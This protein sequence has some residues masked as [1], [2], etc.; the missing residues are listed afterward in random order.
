VDKIGDKKGRSIHLTSYAPEEEADSLAHTLNALQLYEEIKAHPSKGHLIHQSPRKSAPLEH[1]R[2]F[3]WHIFNETLQPFISTVQ[4]QVKQAKRPTTTHPSTSLHLS[5]KDLRVVVQ[6]KLIESHFDEQLFTAPELVE[7]IERIIDASLIK[8]VL[9]RE[10]ALYF[11]EWVDA[12]PFVFVMAF[13]L[14][15]VDHKD[16][17]LVQNTVITLHRKDLMDFTDEEEEKKR[18]EA[19][20]KQKAKKERRNAAATPNLLNTLLTGLTEDE[21]PAGMDVEEPI[22]QAKIQYLNSMTLETE[23]RL[24]SFINNVRG[25][26]ISYRTVAY[27]KRY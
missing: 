5:N 22:L 6:D 13:R 27:V 15:L 17:F 20:A 24:K 8:V 3:G 9:F 2:L 4:Y 7:A 18:E 12:M 19:L 25:S 1:Q 21:E 23:V 14:L 10:L 16:R 11:F 26:Y